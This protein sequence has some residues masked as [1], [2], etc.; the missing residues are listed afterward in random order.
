VL[1]DSLRESLLNVKK[2]ANAKSVVVTAAATRGGITIVV[3]DD[4][5]GQGEAAEPTGWGS[6]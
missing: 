2:H 3:A 4:G 5:H 1:T 6:G